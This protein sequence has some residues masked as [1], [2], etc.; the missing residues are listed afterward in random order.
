MGVGVGVG[1]RG[2]E[3]RQCG[4]QKLRFKVVFKRR[5]GGLSKMSFHHRE[6]APRGD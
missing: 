3:A 6:V 2:I 5:R 1:D 4:V